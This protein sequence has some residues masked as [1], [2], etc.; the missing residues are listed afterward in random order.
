MKSK[1]F[2]FYLGP[3]KNLYTI[4]T[5]LLAYHSVPLDALVN[6]E[7]EEAKKGRVFWEE[8]DEATFVRFCEYAYTGDYRPAAP[9]IVLDSSMIGG[10]STSE[11]EKN[12]DQIGPSAVESEGEKDADQ[13]AMEPEVEVYAEADEPT[14]IG[15]PVDQTFDYPLATT[16][17][18]GRRKKSRR[19][20]WDTKN[21][22]SDEV[23]ESKWGGGE[24]DTGQAVAKQPILWKSFTAK[25]YFT[26]GISAPAAPFRPRAN[27]ERCED[28]TP[29]FL[30]HARMYVFADEW[31]IERLRFIS[32]H[33][34]QQ[35][36]MAFTIYDDSRVDD[37]VSLLRFVYD[38]TRSTPVSPRPV[39]AGAVPQ[40]V[41]D[42]NF[43]DSSD[44]D[45]VV[46]NRGGHEHGRDP[47][48]DNVNASHDHRH[49]H[50]PPRRETTRR[51]GRRERK[52]RNGNHQ[53]DL[54]EL[55]VLYVACNVEKFA[56]NLAWQS[57]LEEGGN[58]PVDLLGKLLSRLT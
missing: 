52:R 21:Y 47:N 24:I 3:N 32:L 8:E 2:E 28:Y 55:V 5:A 26:G 58:L 39:V 22:T 14:T 25:S 16:R 17:S 38:H 27:V 10:L 12:A 23:C 44:D 35:T 13:A 41:R 4:H 9:D 57:L 37:L 11:G 51:G 19:S 18:S 6:G 54:R 20:A 50:H 53:D 42:G 36:L 43:A 33:K 45:I 1:P 34:L 29:V 40:G 49:P 7:M 46:G 31:D 15:Y 56:P 30:S 48:D